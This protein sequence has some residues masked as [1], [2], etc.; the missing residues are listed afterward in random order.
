M[1]TFVVATIERRR[2]F[3]DIGIERRGGKKAREEARNR[4]KKVWERAV[5]ISDNYLNS[6]VGNTMF[7][8]ISLPAI[9]SAGGICVSVDTDLFDII[10]W[11]AKTF[12]VPVVVKVKTSGLILRIVTVYGS[13]Y[14][15]KKEAFSF[16]LHSLFID[17]QGHSIIGGDFNLVRYQGDKS[18]GII[19]HRWGDKFNAWVEIWSLLEVK[20]SNGKFTWGNNQENLIMSNIDRVFCNVEL[21]QNFPLACIDHTPILW[22]SGCGSTTKATIYRFEKWRLMRDEFKT[23]AKQIWAKPVKEGSP[24]DVWQEFFWRFRKWSKGWSKNIESELRNLKR[25]S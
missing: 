18:N 3:I 2:P 11:E 7:S 12:S 13:S 8:W 1:P 4:G 6:L 16:E 9:G 14:E 15:E 10:S 19:D 17:Y 5:D 23:L 22:D 24:I 21:D 20:L 25:T